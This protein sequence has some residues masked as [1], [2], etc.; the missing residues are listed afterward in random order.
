[1]KRVPIDDMMKVF[2]VHRVIT[3]LRAACDNGLTG[4]TKISDIIVIGRPIWIFN[5]GNP[6]HAVRL[7][8]DGTSLNALWSE[9]G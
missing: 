7:C 3:L 6:F 9:T 4:K 8:S 5:T 2:A 1:M